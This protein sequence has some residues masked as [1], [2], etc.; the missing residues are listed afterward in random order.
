MQGIAAR[1]NFPCML[2]W[3]QEVVQGS[4]VWVQGSAQQIA[5]AVVGEGMELSVHAR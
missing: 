1:S 2:C 3:G 4:R 5:C